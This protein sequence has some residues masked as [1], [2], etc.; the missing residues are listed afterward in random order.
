MGRNEYTNYLNFDYMHFLTSLL[1]NLSA[2]LDTYL[3]YLAAILIVIIGWLLALFLKKLVRRLIH[4]TGVDDRLGNGKVILSKFLAKLFYFLMMIFVFMLALEKLGLQ[5]VLDPVKNLLDSFLTFIPNIIGAGLV[6]YVGYMLA[7]IVSQLVGLSGETLAQLSPK[8]KL[9]EN[10]NVVGILK[11]IV[12]IFVFIPILIAALNILNL[13]AIST[14]ATEMLSQFF[15]AIPSIFLAVIILA[16]FI[17]G[18]RFLSTW[19][20]ELL[21]SLRL[22][23]LVQSMGLPLKGKQPN[24]AK[25]IANLVYYFI[26]LFGML[27]VVEKLQFDQLTKILNTVLYLSGNILFGFIILIL[28]NAIAQFASTYFMKTSD[29]TFVGAV[30]KMAIIGLFLAMGLK[31]MGL[32]DDIINL[33]LALSWAP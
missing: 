6:G 10:L 25:V 33:P 23:T 12:F 15:N 4:K 3:Q 18:G 22:D 2:S 28:G 21:D 30:I 16:V 32:G 20:T 19:I 14:P 1:N 29:N 8:L 13:D 11:K 7:S 26:L 9:P 27:T 24:V 31:V 5:S 17:I